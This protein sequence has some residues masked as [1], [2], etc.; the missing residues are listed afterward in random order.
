MVGNCAC[1]SQSQSTI[2]M[3]SLPKP[4]VPQL[5]PDIPK[6][7]KSLLHTV[8]RGDSVDFDI[9]E[10]DTGTEVILKLIKAIKTL[11][12]IDAAV[13]QVTTPDGT[14]QSGAVKIDLVMLGLDQVDNTR[15]SQKE[16]SVPV[17]NELDKKANLETAQFSGR[18]EVPTAPINEPVDNRAANTAF[19]ASYI[20]YLKSIGK[21][22]EGVQGGTITS[23][24]G[25][26]PDVDGSLQLVP[27]DLDLGNVNNTKDADKPASD[28]VLAL[29]KTLGVK[30]IADT[31]TLSAISGASVTLVLVQGVGLFRYTTAVAPNGVTVF[32]AETTG[33]W[34][35]IEFEPLQTALTDTAT[36]AVNGLR[37]G[38]RTVLIN[39]TRTMDAPI[40]VPAN[41]TRLVFEITQGVASLEASPFD[42]NWHATYKFAAGKPKPVL[43]GG[44]GKTDRIEFEYNA[45]D[46]HWYCTGYTLGY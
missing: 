27:D 3:Q 30:V 22:I 42:M 2:P 31:T 8:W 36:I 41:R 40:G 11:S 17:R 7:Y 4:T 12:G 44:V 24:N 35:L 26:T 46:S 33:V 15:D 43:T 10:G 32:T 5:Q 34:Q 37:G 18:I 16:V 39:A 45:A 29:F 38:Y 6:N 25:Q 14:V 9:Q 1:D 13:Y 21:L 23:I 20:N 28:A 19:V